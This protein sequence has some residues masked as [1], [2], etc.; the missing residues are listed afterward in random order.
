QHHHAH[1]ASC[2]A[3]HQLAGPVIGVTLDGTGY[4]TDGAIWGGEFLVGDYCSF[5]RAAHLRY[6]GMPGGGQ[7]IR[8]PWRVA[9][10]HLKDA[11]LGLGLL[12]ARVSLPQLRV[13]EQMMGQR[14]N[15]PQ[16]SSAGRLFD[17]V[18][19]LAGVRDHVSYE[20]QAAIELECLAA[21]VAA[22]EPYP[23]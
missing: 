16:T 1:L 22:A 3:E 11:A 12:A 15:T 9:A 2:M 19:S 20:G 5:R 6:V 8:E 17:A 23:F 18:A 14:L 13:I 21:E 4:G 10:S 7:A